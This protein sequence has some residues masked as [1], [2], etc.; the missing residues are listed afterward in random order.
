MKVMD[1]HIRWEDNAKTWPCT[2]QCIKYQMEII[3]WHSIHFYFSNLFDKWCF[4][5]IFFCFFPI[6]LTLQPRKILLKL[7]YKGP[8][9]LECHFFL[10]FS[11]RNHRLRML[12]SLP[13]LNH[14]FYDNVMS[15][16]ALKSQIRSLC[17]LFPVLW[18]S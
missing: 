3:N 5:R 11:N 2:V 13:S 9:Y 18:C 10:F 6:L 14:F 15:D 17:T 12:V 16:C 7:P 8:N 4:L 1:I